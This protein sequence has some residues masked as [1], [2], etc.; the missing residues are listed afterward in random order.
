MFKTISFKID[1]RGVGTLMLNRPEKH[2]ALSS[3]MIN[4]LAEVTEIINNEKAL[5]VVVL[6]GEGPSFCAG[7]DLKWMQEQ[8]EAS[9]DQ[10]G[11]EAKKL[12]NMLGGLNLLLKPLIGLIHGNVFGG[13]VG[14]A[15]VCDVVVAIDDSKFGFTETRLGLIPATIGPYVIRRMTEAKARTVFMSSRIFGANEAKDFN[16]VNRI[17]KDETKEKSLELEVLPYLDCD[18]AAVEKAKE[19]ALRLSGV[20]S[21]EE[22]DYSV[23]MLVRQ[24]ESE[25]AKKGI[26][27][28]FEKKLRR[29]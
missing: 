19:L 9:A 28:F 2:N 10:R 1:K 13:G 3:T 25:G 8:M 24:W 7:A 27:S 16:I 26:K 6:R 12:A 20:P 5:R 29:R 23:S 22:I 4:E 11:R 17:T 15:C 18:S 14:L 21:K